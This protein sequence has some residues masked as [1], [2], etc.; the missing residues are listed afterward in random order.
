[1]ACE[2][3]VRADLVLVEENTTYPD[4]LSLVSELLRNLTGNSSYQY[5]SGKNSIVQVWTCS[6]AC[7]WTR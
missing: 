3:E 2:F 7:S 6:L 4:M 5:M 1:M